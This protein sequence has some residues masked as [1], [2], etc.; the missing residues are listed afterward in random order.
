MNKM[1][2]RQNLVACEIVILG[3]TNWQD[4]LADPIQLTSE[5][6]IKLCGGKEIP[7]LN[8]VHKVAEINEDSFER[9]AICELLN[10][11]YQLEELEVD[12]IN[13]EQRKWGRCTWYKEHPAYSEPV[14]KGFSHLIPNFLHG[15]FKTEKAGDQSFCLYSTQLGGGILLHKTFVYHK[16]VLSQPKAKNEL[17]TENAGVWLRKD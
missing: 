7:R 15:M 9:D 2:E 11:G 13:E 5:A 6:W 3:L 4:S 16:V 1:Q 8:Y 17:I 14:P 12:M 10:M